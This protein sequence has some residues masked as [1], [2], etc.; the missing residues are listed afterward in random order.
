MAASKPNV[1]RATPISNLPE[2][3]TAAEAAAWLGVSK[4]SAYDLCRRGLLPTTR[5]GR[6]V[7]IQRA[8]LEHL[9]G[10]RTDETKKTES[11]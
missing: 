10:R 3:L 5:L 4:W 2:L 9:A 11:R 1:T 7:R 6:H 8:G